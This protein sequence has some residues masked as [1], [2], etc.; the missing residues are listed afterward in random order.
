MPVLSM[1]C[2]GAQTCPILMLVWGCELLLEPSCPLREGAASV[3]VTLGWEGCPW[4]H[5]SST[6]M[7]AVCVGQLASFEDNF[8]MENN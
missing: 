5:A 3:P 1:F 8:S 2:V 6:W 4:E 7:F